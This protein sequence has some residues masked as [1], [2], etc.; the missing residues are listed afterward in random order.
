M[1]AAL[2]SSLVK[3]AE[4]YGTP[5]YVYDKSTITT[6]CRSLLDCI[7]YPKKKLLYAMKA[8]SNQAVL[9][10]IIGESFGVDCVSLGE[11]LFAKKLGASFIL[12]T[13]NNVNDDEFRGA[14][15]L[16]KA[17]AV[18]INCDSLQRL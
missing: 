14:V 8:N 12:Y 13:N 9:K 1:E 15:E 4:T 7:V 17:G 18:T 3:A 5:V 16:S 10:T 6:R 11:A 2:R